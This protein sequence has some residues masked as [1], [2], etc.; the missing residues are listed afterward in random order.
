MGTQQQRLPTQVAHPIAPAPATIRPRAAVSNELMQERVR[1]AT[2]AAGPPLT[3][4]TPRREELGRLLG[5]GRDTRDVVTTTR[6]VISNV[7]AVSDGVRGRSENDGRAAVSG[8]QELLGNAASAATWANH[9]DANRASAHLGN[10]G[11]VLGGAAGVMQANAGREAFSRATNADGRLSAGSEMVQGARGV[12]T[13]GRDVLGRAAAV[14]NG[15]AAVTAETGGTAGQLGRAA[16]HFGTV[17]RVLDGVRGGIDTARGINQIATHTS[18]PDQMQAGTVRTAQGVVRT[19]GAAAGPPGAVVSAV[20]NY[21]IEGAGD[22]AATRRQGW[23]GEQRGGSEWAA[24]TGRDLETQLAGRY[25]RAA[26]VLG[27]AATAAVL[28]AAAATN[29]AA[30]TVDAA[31]GAADQFARVTGL[32]GPSAAALARAPTARRPTVPQSSG[33]DPLLAPARAAD[34]RP[35]Q[36]DAAGRRTAGF[37]AF[38]PLA[39]P[40]SEPVSTEERIRRAVVGE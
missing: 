19:L 14:A 36:V 24:D 37:P 30:H 26:P 4:Y 18:D 35:G 10:A 8:A 11:S 31:N 27:R 7:G 20:G 12:T 9:G 16:G 21:A 3:S 2:P 13:A 38:T 29:I 40:G 25:P 32:T 5:V 34:I 6:D 39:G 23:L 15:G 28:P 22:D 33:P 1:A 17:A